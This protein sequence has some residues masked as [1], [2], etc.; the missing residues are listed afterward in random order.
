MVAKLELEILTPIMTQCYSV[1][2]THIVNLD[3]V[4][5]LKMNF[6]VDRKNSKEHCMKWEKIITNVKT[7]KQYF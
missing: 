3:P 5:Y 7:A 1:P 2:G 6:I 4:S